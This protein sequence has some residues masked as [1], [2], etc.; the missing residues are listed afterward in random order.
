MSLVNPSEPGGMFVMGLW[1]FAERWSRG[2]ADHV[3]GNFGLQSVARSD[4]GQG[5]IELHVLPSNLEWMT[6]KIAFEK[7]YFVIALERTILGEAYMSM[8]QRIPK[9]LDERVTAYLRRDGWHSGTPSEARVPMA[10]FQNFTAEDFLE[11]LNACAFT[12]SPTRAAAKACN[13][14]RHQLVCIDRRP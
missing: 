9:R 1:M 4:Q 10:E 2:F 14:C 5:A 12:H 8:G 11:W 6:I 3:F 13:T 7:G